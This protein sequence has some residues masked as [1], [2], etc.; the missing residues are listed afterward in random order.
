LIPC[1]LAELTFIASRH[2]GG[3]QLAIP[4]HSAFDIHRISAL[5]FVP[6]LGI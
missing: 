5:G 3:M 6:H 2:W 1:F 4:R